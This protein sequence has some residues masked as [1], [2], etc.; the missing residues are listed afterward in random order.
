[1]A[2]PTITTVGEQV[3]WSYANLARAHAALKAGRTAYVQLDHIIRSRLFAGLLSGVM[4][5]RSLYDDERDKAL[6]ERACVYCG[7]VPPLSIDHLIPRIRGGGD[8]D[9]NLV[10]ACRPCNSAKGG[11]DL[12]DWCEHRN[13]FPPI[14]LLRRYLKLVA[15]GCA[16]G[17]LLDCGL[18]DQAVAELPFAVRGLPTVFPPLSELTL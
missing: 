1:M 16:E 10:L 15:V 13:R 5:M 11:S 18:D 14:L 6:G 9:A 8:E 2:A 12:L 17:R 4:S 3:A 7:A